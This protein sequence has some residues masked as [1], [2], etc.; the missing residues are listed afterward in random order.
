MSTTFHLGG[1]TIHRIVEMEVGITPILDFLPGLTAERLAEN[2]GWLAPA[3]VDAEG[4]VVLCFQSY[5]VRT[6]H[7]VILVDSCIGNDKSFPQRAEWHRKTD[8]VFTDGLAAAGL[9]VAD[10]G[11]VVC[12]HLHADHVGW[13]TRLEDGRWVPT[14]PNAR[15]VFSKDELAAWTTEHG[16]SHMAREESVLPILETGRAELVSSD[17][18]LGDHLRLLA[19]PG[20]TRDHFAVELGRGGAAAVISGD[21]IH[22][23]I[24]ARYPELNMRLDVDPVQAAVTR[25]GFLE[26]YCGTETRC[27]FAHFP[28]PSTGRVVRWGDGF[29]CD[30]VEDE[31]TD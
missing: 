19:T 31:L 20:H 4:R 30:P 21:L 11:Y 8:R 15:Y 7:H 9:T 28:S 27:C 2:H 25:R 5:V 1:L 3:G 22:S 18:A 14:F 24:Q 12:T 26:R 17:Y 6:P 13:N 16:A 10:V 29:R 23:P